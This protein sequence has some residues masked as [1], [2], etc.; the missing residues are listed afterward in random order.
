MWFFHKLNFSNHFFFSF[1]PLTKYFQSC[2]TYLWMVLMKYLI[3]PIFLPF[4]TVF[5]HFTG[6]NV[7]PSCAIKWVIFILFWKFEKCF[8]KFNPFEMHSN[9]CSISS[10]TFFVEQICPIYME[11]PTVSILAVRFGLINMYCF[12]FKIS[13]M[14]R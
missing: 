7:L 6:K 12:S 13:S 8:I 10:L 11:W 3:F 1:H 2:L 9:L 14:L 4:A 5:L